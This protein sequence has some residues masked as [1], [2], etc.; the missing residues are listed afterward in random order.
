MDLAGIDIK[1]MAFIGTDDCSD[2]I[3]RLAKYTDKIYAA[4]SSAYGKS[5]FPGGNITLI[6]SYLDDLRH[7]ISM[8]SHVIMTKQIKAG[9]TSGY[10]ARYTAENDEIIAT[11]PIGYADG[12]I[13]ANTGRCVWIDGQFAQ[14]CGNVCMDQIMVRLEKD[15]PVGTPVEIFGPHIHLEQMAEELH[16]IPYE[17]ICLISG[18][19]TRIYRW[20]NEEELTEENARLI[21]SEVNFL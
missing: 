8:Y 15:V 3:T 13:R 18:R 12:F 1:I 16:T 19:V 7:P 17:I 11:I 2:L 6:S 4:V 5:V 14:V 21:K 9:E 20:H 10:G